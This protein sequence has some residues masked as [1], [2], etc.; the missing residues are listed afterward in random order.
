MA[1]NKR[2]ASRGSGAIGDAELE[3]ISSGLSASFQAARE[4]L[5]ES[6]RELQRNTQTLQ[7]SVGKLGT[8]SD[9]EALREKLKKSLTTAKESVAQ[10]SAD[11]RRLKRNVSADDKGTEGT[12]LKQYERKVAEVVHEYRDICKENANRQ[13]Q[14]HNAEREANMHEEEE[15]E[16][17]EALL[18]RM[19]ER[20]QLVD[21]NALLVAE[22]EEEIKEIESTVVEIY[23]IANELDRMVN[24]QGEM[25]DE[26]DTNVSR[27]ADHVEAGQEQLSMANTSAK[28]SRKLKCWLLFFSVLALAIIILW[29]TNKI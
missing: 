20:A 26:V 25:I 11:L 14:I 27:G 3:I 6:I 17:D 9:G 29:A 23:D 13:R 18:Q 15:G 10:A 21:W 12:V 5:E 16:E 2:S 22:R 24:N 8:G 28:K 4:T 19:Q 7:R 1:Y